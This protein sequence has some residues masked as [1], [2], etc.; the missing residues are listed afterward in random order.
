MF[1][2]KKPGTNLEKNK[3]QLCDSYQKINCL[4]TQVFSPFCYVFLEFLENKW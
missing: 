2:F 3:W 1:T 4:S